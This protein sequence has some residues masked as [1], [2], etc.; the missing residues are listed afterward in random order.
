MHG[1]VKQVSLDTKESHNPECAVCRGNFGNIGINNK[2]CYENNGCLLK[3]HR[4]MEE[5][6]I[7]LSVS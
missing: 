2:G 5:S 7:G 3:V 1:K 4:S 6:A